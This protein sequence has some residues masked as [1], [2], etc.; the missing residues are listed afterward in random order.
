QLVSSL[1]LVFNPSPAQQKALDKLLSDQQNST[2]PNYHKW[3]TPAR[4]ADRFGMS[5][6]DIQK[7]TSWLQSQGFRVVRIANS[8]NQIF[9]EGTISQIETTFRTEMHDYLVD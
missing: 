5:R 1:S 7:V 6:N 2:S 8:R 3:L 9:F 4:F